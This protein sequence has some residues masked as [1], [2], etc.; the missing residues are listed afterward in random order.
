[1]TTLA[2][3]HVSVALPQIRTC[4]QSA[5]EDDKLRDPAFSA[6]VALIS[7]AE[8]EDIDA[9]VDHTFAMI[10]QHLSSLNPAMRRKAYDMLS[11][12]LKAHDVFFRERIGTLPLLPDVPLLSKHR[13]EIARLKAAMDP[14]AMFA[15]F[16]RRCEDESAVVVGQALRELVPYLTENQRFIHETSVSQQPDPVVAQLL[17]SLLDAT[18]RFSEDH[19]DIVDL[20]SQCLGLVGCLNPYKVEA[21]R[22]KQDTLVLSNFERADEIVDFSAVL[23]PHVLVPAFRSASNAKAQGFL[24]YAMQEI[25][26]ACGYGIVA[27]QR[28]R[29]S[30][31]NSLSHQRWLEMSESVRSTLTPF[32]SSRYIFQTNQAQPVKQTY[33]I[34]NTEISHGTW[35]R[36]FVYDLLQRGKGENAQRIFPVIARVIRGQDLSIASFM[37]PFAAANIILGGTDQEARDVGQELLTVLKQEIRGTVFEAETIRQCS[38]SVF[39]VLDYL[40][41]WLQEKRSMLGDSRSASGRRSGQ[42]SELDDI[43]DVAQIS[44]VERILHGIPAEVISHRAVECRSYARAL[45]H[46]EQYI[47]QEQEKTPASQRQ[48]R[49]EELYQYLQDIY[50]QIDEPDGTEGVSAHLHVLGPE[51]QVLEHRKAGRWTAAQSWYEL[52]L[53]EKPDDAEVQINLLTCLKE[54]GQYDAVLRY[55]DSFQAGSVKNLPQLLPFASEAS[56][57]TGKWRFLESSI[58]AASDSLSE[59]FNVGVGAALVALRQNKHDEFL[60]T[61]AILRQK[62]ARSLSASST[63]SVQACHGHLLKL[64]ALYEMEAI[65]GLNPSSRIDREIMLATLD[66]RLEVL[67]TYT[68]DKQYL[69]GVRRAT[70]QLTENKFSKLD[71]ASSWLTTSKLA[72]KADFINTAHNAVLHATQLGD[73]AARI[74]HARLLWKEDH[75]RKAIQSLE[76]AIAANAFQSHDLGSVSESVSTS[77][78]KEKFQNFLAARAHVLLAKWL[79]AS[80]QTPSAVIIRK[81]QLAVQTHSRWEKGHY[82]LGKHYNKLLQSEKA[83]PRSKQNISFRSGETAKLVVDNFIRSMCFGAKYY[84]QT[85]PRLLTVWLDLGTDVHQATQRVINVE[86]DILAM[87]IRNLDAMHRQIRKYVERLPGYIFYTAFPQIITRISHPNTKVWEVLFTIILKVV[88][89]HSQQALWYVLAVVKSTAADR[90]SRGLAVVNKLK[91]SKADGSASDL[92]TMIVHGQKLSDQLLHACE[93]AVDGRSSHASLSR[94]LGFNHKLAPCPLVVPIETT[95]TATLPTIQDSQ[96]VRLHKAFSGGNITISSF[97]DDVLVLSS[98]QRPRKLVVRGSDGRNYGLLCKPKDDLRKDQRLM[99]FNA[100]INRG[101]QKDVEASKRRLYIKTYGVT[102]LNEECG[103]IEWVDNLKPMRDIIIK[104]YKQKSVVIDYNRIRA[105]LNESIAAPENVSIFTD[106]ILKLFFPV[107]HE[108]F[109][110]TFPEPDDWFKARL[111][112]TRSCAVM[113][114]VGHVLG[115][116]DRHGENLLLEEGTG[117]ILHVDFN[118]LFDKGLTFEKPE[119]VPFRLTHNMVDAMGAYGYEGPFRAAAELTLTILR[120]NEDTLMTILETFV[121]DPTTDFIGKKKRPTPGVPETPQEVL[122]SVRGKLAGLLRG[123]SV[124]L[125]VEGYVE[126]LIQM[127]RDPKRLAA[128]YIGWCAFF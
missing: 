104:L 122:E 42:P 17:R 34:F 85:V 100:M 20:C 3:T 108:W 59:H 62:I 118:C 123:E 19:S 9:L 82:Y 1:M 126:A 13:S 54:S 101:L 23:L 83:M 76:G 48:Q 89:S 6:W 113:S 37:L 67:G 77:G 28:T 30:Q 102:P 72:R 57:V 121:Y 46:W 51:Q 78:D 22:D 56:W 7:V 33:P 43:R 49:N 92:R 24:A 2:K 97:S 111:R 50:A 58:H 74:E 15:A 114:I 117:G 66:R 98:L 119:V 18:V 8:E 16:S 11:N 87:Q 27:T 106:T 115:L 88:S 125:S 69:L 90:S 26:K 91:K 45:F 109:V 35:L 71:L 99:E 47:R 61:L 68:S 36:T 80:G 29:S 53:V 12:M 95:M 120:Q 124:P 86:P 60:S 55:V 5:M 65:S 44:S 41:R 39:H 110:E 31:A 4:L 81:Y 14:T 112:Y 21:A 10:A 63:T 25:L 116:G 105:L 38:E 79:D 128:M 73:D 127:A 40:S 64:H 107:L 96:H 84:Y 94:D 75:H 52:E 103:T 70:M 93:V 32:L